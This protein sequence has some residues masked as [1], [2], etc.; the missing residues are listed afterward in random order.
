MIALGYINWA[1]EGVRLVSNRPTDW[2]SLPD[3]EKETGFQISEQLAQLTSLVQRFSACIKLAS[4]ADS[5]QYLLHA[6]REFGEQFWTLQSWRSIAQR[7]AGLSIYDFHR[8][9]VAI[10]I[11]RS[12]ARTIRDH[13]SDRAISNAMQSFNEAFPTAK[14][15]RNAYA[16][17]SDH[18][19]TP[20]RNAFSG[21]GSF[22]GI[23]MQDCEQ[24]MIVGQFGE[25]A[26]V[27]SEGS[28]HTFELNDGSRSRLDEV[29]LS[30]FSAFEPL[31]DHLY[32]IRLAKL[33]AMKDATQS[34]A[35]ES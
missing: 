7:D 15:I 25:T 5:Q 4:F 14:N 29:R 19:N 33:Q 6:R 31:D 1:D 13:V 30:I 10:K 32:G 27:T 11:A 12:K 9:M 22:P 20:E 16:H 34:S 2:S 26:F 24:V 17:M 21:N 8:G 35:S 3:D 18:L 23:E 28:I